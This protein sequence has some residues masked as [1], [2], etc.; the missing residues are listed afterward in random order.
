MHCISMKEAHERPAGG[1][2]LAASDV[3]ITAVFIQ[4]PVGLRHLAKLRQPLTELQ[5]AEHASTVAVSPV[6]S[7]APAE[8]PSFATSEREA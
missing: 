1:F 3:A 6:M 5:E 2:P 7:P 8:A 4:Q